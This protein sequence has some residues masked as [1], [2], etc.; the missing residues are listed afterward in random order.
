MTFKTPV[1]LRKWPQI[2]VMMDSCIHPTQSVCGAWHAKPPFVK[3]L[4]CMLHINTDS[5]VAWKARILRV[6]SQAP[7]WKT[8]TC[9]KKWYSLRIGRWSPEFD[10]V[11]TLFLLVGEHDRVKTPFLLVIAWILFTS[12]RTLSEFES[13]MKL[14]SF[15]IVLIPLGK[16]HIQLFSFQQ[17][18]NSRT[19]WVL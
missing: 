18:V 13:L 17:W 1:Y 8:T 6:Q 12:W 15:Y 11:K 4:E 14:F 7:G 19:D 9:L 2:S 3:D 5:H 10:Q 16:V